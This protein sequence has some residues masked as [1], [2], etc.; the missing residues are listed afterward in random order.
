MGEAGQR[1]AFLTYTSP[2]SVTIRSLGA[3]S[4]SGHEGKCCDAV[5]R[6]LEHRLAASRADVHFPDRNG[7]GGRPRGDLC[8]RLGN[9]RYAL[10]HTLIEPFWLAIR[11]GKFFSNLVRPLERE[12][13]EALPGP[14][15]FQLQFPQDPTEGLPRRR[16]AKARA[17][18]AAWISREAP[19]LYARALELSDSTLSSPRFRARVIAVPAGLPYPVTLACRVLPSRCPS[20]LQGL[21]CVRV[22][23][24]NAQLEAQRAE[25][26]RKALSDKCPKLKRCRDRG[27]RSVL[28]LQSDD[29]ALT[30]SG[31]VF[32]ALVHAS[33]GRADL[34]D[35][36]YLVET[37]FSSWAVFPMNPATLEV[38]AVEGHHLHEFERDGLLDLAPEAAD[39]AG[40]N[41]TSGPCALCRNGAACPE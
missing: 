3:G 23:A 30:N 21:R 7:G 6:V 38:F 5:L 29:V 17:G 2:R 40:A 1:C 33:A 24:G 9:R 28:V 36:I 39:A 12:L 32:D 4:M 35:E 8:V 41:G 31:G 37:D 27:A 34:P 15:E 20:P 11:S 10:E 13:S 16:L 26:L 19:A 25:R 18:L 14:A 22:A